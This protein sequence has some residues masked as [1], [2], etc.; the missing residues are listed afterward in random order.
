[1]PGAGSRAV[2]ARVLRR[3]DPRLLMGKGQY[4]DDL[5]VAGVLHAAFV[6]SSQAHAT[7]GAID[8][9]AARVT[10]GVVGVFTGGDLAGLVLPIRATS[11]TQGY[12]ECDTPV[13]ASGKVRFVGEPV[14]VVVAETRYQAEDGAEA[15]VVEYE[16]LSAVTEIEQALAEGAPAIHEEIPDNLFTAWEA[17]T[18]DVEGAFAAADLTIELELE[19]QRHSAA[20]LEGRAVLASFDAGQ[21]ELTVWLSSQTPHVIRTGLAR[22]LQLPEN[23]IRVVSPNVGGG[24]GPKCVLYQEEVALGAVSKLLGRPVKWTSDRIED[25]Q[26]TIHGREQIHRIKAAATSEG[27][28]L[29]IKIEIFAS[30]GAYAPWPLTAGLDSGNAA[31]N[32]LGPYETPAYERSVH[33]VVTN[34]APMGPYR[35]VGRVPACFSMERVMD[36][37][38]SRLELDPLEVRRRNFVRE[39]PHST[40]TGDRYESGDYVKCLELLEE[41]L[42]Y[43]RVREENRALQKQGRYRGIG[44]ACAV[45]H[46]ALGPKEIGR[47]NIAIGLGYDTSSVRVEPDG[48]VRIAV[49]LHNHG[50][51]HATTIAQIASDELGI[52]VDDIEVVWGDTAVVPYGIGTFASRSTVYCGGATILAAGDVRKKMLELA[53]DM[54]EANADDLDLADGTIFVIGTPTRNVSFAEVARRANHLPHLLPDGMEPGLESTRRYMAPEPGSY[55]NAMHG[56][57]VEV[58]VHTGLVEILRYVVVEDCGTIINPTIVE[59][60]IHGGVA[61]GIGGALLEHLVY[62][63][64]GQL[65]TT[66]FMDYLLPG[67]MEVPPIEVIHLETP[68]PHTLGGFKGMGEG[69]AINAP[70]AI[71]AAVNDALAPFG[72]TANHTPLMPEWIVDAVRSSERHRVESLALEKAS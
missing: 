8:T 15:V 50:Q 20:A 30:N 63:Q 70:V 58:D 72:I 18:G 14:A 26:T 19:M 7:L 53:A 69:G 59:G 66:T 62:D 35:G 43:E 49:G 44:I 61:Q 11:A 9:E 60:Q 71:V 13:L 27:R 32:L 23:K 2:G 46:S 16:P 1:M 31:H 65:L 57:V 25:L 38:A 22:F 33:A 28:L 64:D 55:S 36:E 56:A 6:R 67:F 47:H 52:P 4:V 37:L 34:K 68:S 41:A 24:F 54:L 17:T 10:P 3:E 12:K 45:E 5:R 21:N 39:F 40:P 51:G 42:D 29:G 48:K